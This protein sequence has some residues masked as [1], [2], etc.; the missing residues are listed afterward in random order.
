M[1]S[2]VA[3]IVQARTGSTRLPEK[4]VRPFWRGE[5]MLAVLLGRLQR[6]LPNCS[7]VVATS[8][9]PT[10]DAI[11][12]TASSFKAVVYRGSENDVLARFREASR[13]VSV[14]WVVRV[15]ADN[16]FLQP[17]Y[18]DQL[19]EHASTA[20]D[21]L[22]FCYP[23][24]TPSIL[25]HAGLFAEV[26]SVNVLEN[27]HLR[28]KEPRHR[29]HLTLQILEDRDAFTTWWLPIPSDVVAIPELRLTVDTAADFE[30]ASM[31]HGRM[32]SQFGLDYRVRDLLSTVAA[33]Q[34]I[35][36]KMRLQIENNRKT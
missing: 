28:C 23:D 25:S 31:L 15:C 36:S 19:L 4:V 33:D 7:L 27:L 3:I 34:G 13:C 22:S 11:E 26:L 18:I 9:L 35:L 21:Y 8:R 10:D 17:T 2:K 5:N 20:V 30:L 29:E 12:E 32:V 24:G 14:D 6:G 16:P 1:S